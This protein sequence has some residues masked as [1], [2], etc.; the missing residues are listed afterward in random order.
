MKMAH[1]RFCT[2]LII[3]L[4]AAPL[5]GAQQQG[6]RGNQPKK[7]K[8]EQLKIAFITRELHLTSE[9]AMEFWPVYNEMTDK[10]REE[11]RN[12]KRINASLRKGM[13]TLS[14][15][16]ISKKTNA[17]FDSQ[18]NEI[19]TQK[20]YT[21]KIAAVVGHK[22]ATKLLSLEQRFKRELLTRIN[23]SNQSP[24]KPRGKG[25]PRMNE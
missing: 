9:Q 8:I 2:V 11:K 12:R 6:Q 23:E 16:E 7:E 20:E 22:K 1:L 3:S 18:I 17:L 5:A 24:Q 19:Q 13:S 10:M 25:G 15:A 21:G 4:L 14:D